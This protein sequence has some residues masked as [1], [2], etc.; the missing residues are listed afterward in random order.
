MND[1]EVYANKKE[2]KLNFWTRNAISFDHEKCNENIGIPK[3]QIIGKI[4][5]SK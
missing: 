5:K 3:D 2:I 1:E 4:E